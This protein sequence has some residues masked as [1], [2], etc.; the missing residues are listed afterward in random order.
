MLNLTL[1]ITFWKVVV[2]ILIASVWVYFKIRSELIAWWQNIIIAVSCGVLI[3]YIFF[4][5]VIGLW[6]LTKL[7]DILYEAALSLL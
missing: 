1:E 6:G 3:A 5:A 7:F 4:M 2:I